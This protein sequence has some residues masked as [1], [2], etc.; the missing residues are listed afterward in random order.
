MQATRQTGAWMWT[1]VAI[2]VVILVVAVGASFSLVQLLKTP[3]GTASEVDKTPVVRVAPLRLHQ[4]EM[5]INAD[6]AV[7]PYRDIELS[8]EVSGRIAS[9]ADICCAGNYV[10]AGTVLVKIDPSDYQLEVERLQ[11]ELDQA[12]VAV[13]E[14]Q[15]QI[16][17][18]EN[19]IKIA[20]SELALRLR[21]LNRQ[22]SL[23]R[24]VSAIDIERAEAN[25]LAARDKMIN[26]TSQLRLLRIGKVRLESARD[27]S[28]SK[29]EKAQLDLNRTQIVAPVDGVVVRHLVET[30]AFVQRGTPLLVLADTSKA[31]VRCKLEMED[32]FWL[33]D[34]TTGSTDSTAGVSVAKAYEIPLTDVDVVYRMAGHDDR[35]YVWAGRLTRYDGIGLDERSRTIPCRV[36]VDAPRQFRSQ[37]P[38]GP[39]ALVRGMYVTVRIHAR[40][41]MELLEIPERALQPGNMIWRVRN[42]KL[43]IVP[44]NFVTLLDV[45]GSKGE[46]DSSRDVLIYLDDPSQ[47]AAGDRVVVSPLA[48]VRSGMNVRVWEEKTERK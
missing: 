35:E 30:G 48:F 3:P 8:A 5:T 47:L 41:T 27:L 15:E 37:Y 44:V 6:G 40:P 11:K 28:T 31:E 4:G 19:R 10:T 43:S 12:T 23:G 13:Q 21:E 22:K 18:I 2:S 14:F 16:V 29:L 32:L 38:N 42:K 26:L 20:Q 39:P 46:A 45:P 36:V 25:E 34:Q 1:Q 24:A 7:V 33:W 17:G 9:R